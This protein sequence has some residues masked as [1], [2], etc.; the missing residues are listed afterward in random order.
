MNKIRDYILVNDVSQGSKEWQEL[1]SKVLISGSTVSTVC[2][3]NKNSLAYLAL[4]R[5]KATKIWNQIQC[6]PM[7]FGIKYEPIARDFISKRLDV[8][9]LVPGLIINK[10]YSM[11]AYSPDGIYIDK[12]DGVRRLLE[13]KC[14]YSRKIIPNFV[15]PEYMHQ[16]QLGMLLTEIK[17]CLYCEFIFDKLTGEYKEHQE[18]IVKSD[19]TWYTKYLPDFKRF[20]I[21]VQNYREPKAVCLLDQLLSDY[22][23]ST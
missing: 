20:E 22:Q 10:H 2:N 17:E 21:D 7:E 16:M 19:P 13:I 23:S 15:P 5:S 4:V 9:I 1:R 14:L 18:I 6:A 8:K 3:Q 11:F 12:N